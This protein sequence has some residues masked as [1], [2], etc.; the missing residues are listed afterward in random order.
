MTRSCI[1]KIVCKR[2]YKVP[3]ATKHADSA[4]PS[5]LKFSLAQKLMTS[6]IHNSGNYNEPLAHFEASKK[7]KQ[8]TQFYLGF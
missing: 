6:Q 2:I 4:T 5:L 1:F 7:M 3:A 8:I